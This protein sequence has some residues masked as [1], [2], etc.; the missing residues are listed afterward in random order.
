MSVRSEPRAQTPRLWRVAALILILGAT[1]VLAETPAERRGLRFLNL[2]CAHCHAVAQTDESPLS[3]A[4][5]LR[6]LH[7]KYPVAD[8]RRPLAKGV[9]PIMPRFELEPDEV[10][11]IMAYLKTL[12]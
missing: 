6:T 10:D 11:D 2:H 5:P 7:L 9:H 1:E 12:Q 4:P 3:R 8:L